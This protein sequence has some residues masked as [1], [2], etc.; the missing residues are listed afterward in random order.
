MLK[1]TYEQPM[2]SLTLAALTE[3]V[4]ADFCVIGGGITGL[5]T[6]LHLAKSGHS[7]VLL[8]AETLGFGASG[9]NGGQVNPGLKTPPDDIVRYFGAERGAQLISASWNAPNRVFEL[10]KEYN[11]ACDAVQGGT[12]RAATAKCQIPPLDDLCSQLKHEN[13]LVEWLDAKAIAS[14]TGCDYYVSGLLDPRGG[15]LNPLAY[16]RGLAQAAQA[17]GARLFEQ[18]VAQ[19]L[20]QQGAGWEVTTAHGR[21]H[22]G[23]VI[24]TTNGYTTGLMPRLKRS[25]VPLYSGIVAS[26][27]LTDDL[28][29]TILPQREVVYELGEVTT[30]YRIDAQKRLLIGGRSQSREAFGP[31]SFKFLIR[32]AKTLWPHLSG[33]AWTHGWNGQLAMTMDHYPHWHNPQPGLYAALGY[34]GRGVA[35]ATVTGQALSEHVTQG[36]P[37]LF[38]FTGINPILGHPFWKIGVSGAILFKRLQDKMVTPKK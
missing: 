26:Q 15:Q 22:A 9:R 8:E 19:K 28:I 27:P 35:M 7:V 38:P 31:Q 3:D 10:I 6:A 21:V 1:T 20:V 2:T 17:E 30:Y 12:I 24:V 14:R 23:A 34:N 13:H 25:I 37:P 33:A 4:T 5:S 32:H 11:I 29:K 18:T 16:T 36:A